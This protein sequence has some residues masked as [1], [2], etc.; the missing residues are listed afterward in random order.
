MEEDWTTW[1]W[2]SEKNEHLEVIVPPPCILWLIRC[3]VCPGPYL[4][5]IFSSSPTKCSDEIP[6]TEATPG[7]RSTVS[8]KMSPPSLAK[9]T[10]P[11]RRDLPPE[12]WRVALSPRPTSRH[13]SCQDHAAPQPPEVKGGLFFPHRTTFR[14]APS[15]RFD[16]PVPSH[17]ENTMLFFMM[18]RAPRQRINP[19][20]T[21]TS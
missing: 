13:F 7:P 9:L 16:C 15:P 5:S 21:T 6:L 11:P 19:S 2:S 18:T 1:G 12:R 8:P 3:H 4:R 20:T 14:A 17:K 10:T